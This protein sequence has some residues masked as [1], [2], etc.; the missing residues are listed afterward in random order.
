MVAVNQALV[1]EPDKNLRHGSRQAGVQGEAFAAPVARGA[2]A[3][4]LME[5]FI[6]VSVAPLPHT[7]DELV[8]AEIVAAFALLS[9]FAFDHVLRRDPRVIGPR[10]PQRVV[11]LHPPAAH[12]Y[13]VECLVERVSK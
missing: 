13:V 6:A 4:E 8:T 11:T 10:Q 3:A 12:D 1:I 5:N 9:E 7:L 2:K